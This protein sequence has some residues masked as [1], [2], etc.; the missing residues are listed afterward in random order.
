MGQHSLETA[1]AQPQGAALFELGVDP[2]PA[3]RGSRQGNRAVV[4]HD[5]PLNVRRGLE[6][7]HL[8]GEGRLQS[9]GTV[10]PRRQCQLIRQG[11]GSVP[12]CTRQP[13][14]ETVQLDAPPFHTGKALSALDL[15]S[16]IERP[17]GG[18]AA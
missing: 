11:I 14:I 16:L 15:M 3:R 5:V 7:G 6:G 10:R 2:D 12:G 4:Q 18:R 17:G 1:E 13:N 8:G 9:V